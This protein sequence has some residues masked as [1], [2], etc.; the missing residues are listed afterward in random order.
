MLQGCVRL[1]TDAALLFASLVAILLLALLRVVLAPPL[2]P[3]E[4]VAEHEGERVSVLARVL[5][6]RHGARGRF[7]MLADETARV[8]ALAGRGDGPF[9]GDFVR[10][11]G[12][13]TRFDDGPGISVESIEVVE[14]AASRPLAPSEIARAP[15]SFEGARVL[16]V[17]ELRDGALVGGGARI[18]VAGHDAPARDGWWLAAGVVRYHESRVAYSLVVDTWTPR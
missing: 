14:N 2:L 10:V 3:V 15:E 6:A 12:V 9:A 7:L 16:L 5:D 13:V 11:V 4:D 8:P 18:A 1:R 17:G